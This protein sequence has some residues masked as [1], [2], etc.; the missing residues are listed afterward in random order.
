MTAGAS[1][2]AEARRQLA[3]AKAHS[4]AA[5]QARQC[6]ARYR[7]AATTEKQTAALL[8]P[9]TSQGHHLLADRGWPG[10]RRSQVDLVVVGPSGVFI[11][12]TKAWAELQI[13]EDRVLRG[14]E[15][16]TDSLAT[17]GLLA[18]D[19]QI[20]L[21]TALGLAPGEVRAVV[22]M[23]GRRDL[24]ARVAGVTIV[25]QH[26]ILSHISSF[27]SRLT[28]AQV[29]SLL[30]AC[31]DFFPVI[32]EPAP[33]M[34]TIVPPVVPI[35]PEPDELF[36]TAEILTA[37]ET[38]A[39]A[40]P[41]EDWM[42]YLHPNQART[43]C[44]YF[45]GPSRVRG[46]AGTGK[47]VVGLHRAAWLARTRPGKVLLT[48]YV[49]TLPDVLGGLLAR[50]AP[51]VTDRIERV[52]IHSWAHRLLRDRGVPFQMNPDRCDRLFR[53]AMRDAGGPLLTI[54]P[55]PGYWRDEIDAVIRGRGITTFDQYAALARTGR[56]QRLTPP[57]RQLVW[58]LLVAYSERLSDHQVI[59][60][61]G[62]ILLAEQ[63]LI[64]EP[65]P[66]YAAVI[67][68]EAQ[69]LSCVMLRMLHRLVGDIDNGLTLIG[70]GQ[71][72][73]YPGGWTLA[74]AGI[75]V[76]GRGVVFDINYRNTEQIHSFASSLVSDD[77]YADLEGTT[78]RG[79][80]TMVV[81][82][83]GSQPHWQQC[84]NQQQ[85]AEFLVAAVQEALS[86]PATEAG[87]I[88]V[89]CLTRKS[90][91]WASDVLDQAHL[92]VS[93]LK[94]YRGNRSR[95]ILVG[96]VKRAK[97]LEFKQVVL[98][99]LP[100]EITGTAPAA[101]ADRERWELQRREAYVAMTRARDRLWVMTHRA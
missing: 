73:I 81:P 26:D 67:V 39:L 54:N 44:R 72:T 18:E 80:P 56:R 83:Q 98:P 10:S 7:I 37:L 95:G 42:T 9:L 64:R 75:S 70:D 96:T 99:D 17:L 89:L 27:G 57:Q 46:P 21:A 59:D 51:D 82:R 63:E 8:H 3:L 32:G 47:T 68:D 62:L 97:G 43:A 11:V 30:A 49:R 33:V 61:P 92:P 12:D 55:D 86:E 5:E 52:G 91:R 79:E 85:Q 20:H 6:A 29:D 84:Q 45:N 76:A 23:A 90:V 78:S 19:T 65:L 93:Q 94:S 50:L 88:A 35:G 60:F 41:I 48:S 58:E 101:D 53:Q 1:A 100:L 24:Q 2:S 77:E 71:Q 66:G 31:Q 14:Q 36:S 15:D 16:V 4:A 38:A 87:D 13:T 25:G 40:A 74:E 22:A 28:E 34:T 69:D